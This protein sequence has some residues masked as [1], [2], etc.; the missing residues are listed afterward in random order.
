MNSVQLIGRL[1]HDPEGDR[2]GDGTTVATF[3]LAVDRP[4]RD[5]AD[6]VTVKV[7]ERTAE[8]VLKHLVRGRR[9]AVQGSLF[10]DEWTR[11]DG[12]RADRLIVVAARVEFLDPPTAAAVEREALDEHA[13]HATVDASSPH[14]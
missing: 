6:F 3:R 11:S 10:H 14:G 2:I 4:R 9:V 5:S 12:K 1:T 13:E 7:W 8:A